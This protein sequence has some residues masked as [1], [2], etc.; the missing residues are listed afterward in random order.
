ML[1]PVITF[2]GPSLS[3]NAAEKMQTKP[4]I[5]LLSAFAPEMA[6]RDQLNSFNRGSKNTPKV[7]QEP[8]TIAIITKA[9][10]AIA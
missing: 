9:A 7:A 1:Q 6:A 10:A 5:R 2:L 8:H 3:L 4:N